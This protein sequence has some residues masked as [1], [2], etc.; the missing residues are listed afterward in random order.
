MI[1]RTPLSTDADLVIGFV[2]LT[3][4]HVSYIQ[5]FEV[6]VS[7]IL[8]ISILGTRAS[9]RLPSK[10]IA[11]DAQRNIGVLLATGRCHL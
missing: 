6:F 5:V 7:V 1:V 8:T 2:Y 11:S 10:M 3:L 9:L 4:G